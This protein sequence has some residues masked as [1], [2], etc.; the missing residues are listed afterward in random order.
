MARK[1][2]TI[3]DRISEITVSSFD[4][5]SMLVTAIRHELIRRRKNESVHI[6]YLVI[7]YEMALTP[8]ELKY[9]SDIILNEISYRSNMGRPPLILEQEWRD[10]ADQIR[11]RASSRQQDIDFLKRKKLHAKS[12]A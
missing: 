5:Y 2:P 1:Q 12:H 8:M 6:P 7:K 4:I 10:W 3:Q 9:I 11:D